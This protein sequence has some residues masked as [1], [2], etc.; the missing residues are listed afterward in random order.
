MRKKNS[1]YSLAKY[2]KKKVGNC[3]LYEVTPDNWVTRGSLPERK[4]Y[5]NS[6]NHKNEVSNKSRWYDYYW[7]DPERRKKILAKKA[8]KKKAMRRKGIKPEMNYINSERGYMR[9][10][11]NSTRTRCKK[12]GT[13]FDLTWEIFWSLWNEQK[14]TYGMLCP[15][16]KVPMTFTRGLNNGTKTKSFKR[17]PTNVS[18]DQIWPGKGYT[19]HNV[20]FCTV[21]ANCDKRSITPD[22]CQAVVDIYNDRCKLTMARKLSI[23]KRGDD[24]HREQ[25]GRII[26][27]R[28]GHFTEEEKKN[29]LEVFYKLAALE[30][31]EASGDRDRINFAKKDLKDH[32][33]DETQ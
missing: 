31:A 18:I 25:L 21:K 19:E 20:L 28:D 15:Y 11:W 26:L 24:Y 8:E 4:A 7:S 30:A 27:N 23:V 5:M 9:S 1:K 29:M 2:K 16:T 33:K 22:M 13:P 10:L 6:W 17:V 12:T 32:Y 3:T 14:L